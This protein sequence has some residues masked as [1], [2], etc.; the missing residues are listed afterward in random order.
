MERHAPDA[1][2]SEA[3]CARLLAFTAWD[4]FSMDEGVYRR[5]GTPPFSFQLDHEARSAAMARKL[6]SQRAAA[7]PAGLEQARQEYAYALAKAPDDWVLHQ[8]LGNLLIAEGDLAG[9]IR[10]YRRVFETIPQAMEPYMRAAFE[11]A[12][13]GQPEEAVAL[14]TANNPDNPRDLADV[15]NDIGTTFSANGDHVRAAGMF[16][17][18]VNLKPDNT[19]ARYNLAMALA[20]Q[21]RVAEAIG[22]FKAL[23]A[24]DPNNADAHYNLAMA[25]A[26]TAQWDEALRHLQRTIEIDPDDEDAH[27]QTEVIQRQ[28]REA[29]GAEQAKG[30]AP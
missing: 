4:Q 29:V 16:R 24:V 10:E 26:G 3:D 23:L 18:A 19:D 20:Q 30:G 6:D 14:I 15:Y 27:H 1:R 9:A 7:G 11:R 12:D 22:E 25:L 8:D 28:L 5:L 17:K 21:G 13:A 2:L